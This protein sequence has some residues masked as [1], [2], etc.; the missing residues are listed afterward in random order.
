MFAE[1]LRVGVEI[2]M[3]DGVLVNTWEDL[4]PSTLA[5]M[6]DKKLLGRVIDAPIYPIGPIVRPVKPAVERESVL[7]WL[8]K[9]PDESVIYVSFGSGGTLSCKQVIELAWGLEMS[10]QRFV[11]VVRPPVD[12]D[13]SASYFNVSNGC[14]DGTPSYL[15]DGFLTRNSEKGLIVQMWAPQTEILGHAAV[16]W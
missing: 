1:F 3:A 13:A 11:W 14:D 7:C 8:D 4:E 6:R 2:A 5:A 9:Q 15:P 12:N 16:V 10:E